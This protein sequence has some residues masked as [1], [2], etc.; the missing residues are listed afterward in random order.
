LNCTIWITK[1]ATELVH[2]HNLVQM[3]QNPSF[4]PFSFKLPKICRPQQ[5]LSVCLNVPSSRSTKKKELSCQ[6]GLTT[7]MKTG[8]HK[9]FPHFSLFCE[10]KNGSWV[11]EIDEKYLLPE[12]TATGKS[13][14]HKH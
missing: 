14:K 6:I 10:S 11:V 2:G 3:W 7:R 13:K 12:W 9:P 4:S 5:Q 1:L 8:K